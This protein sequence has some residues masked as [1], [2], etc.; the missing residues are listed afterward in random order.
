[1]TAPRENPLTEIRFRI[2][3]DRI[4]SEHVGPAVSTLLPAARGKLETIASADGERTFTGTMERLDRL[5]ERLDYCMSVV[6]HLEAVATYP[7]L[8]AAYNAVQPKVAA[9]SSSI[10]L[11]AALYR[12]LKRY[13]D[14]P[15]YSNA[16]L[17]SRL[18]KQYCGMPSEAEDLDRKSTRLNSSHT[19]ISRMPSSA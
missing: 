2:P 14:E 15:I 8:R 3:F 10:P 16:E 5:T 1:M 4:R 12:Q 6:R 9:F 11:N 19:D 7:E 18:M 13:A 17:N